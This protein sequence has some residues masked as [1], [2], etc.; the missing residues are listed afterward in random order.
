[1]NVVCLKLLMA[2]KE[3]NSNSHAEK[4]WNSLREGKIWLDISNSKGGSSMIDDT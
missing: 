1:M 4:Q 2:N 3:V